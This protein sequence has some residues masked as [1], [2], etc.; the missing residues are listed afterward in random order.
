MSPGI[1][2]PPGVLSL[3]RC[4]DRGIIS[5]WG[6]GTWSPDYAERHYGELA[7]H[8]DETRTAGL[9]VRIL[10]N[11]QKSAALPDTVA[12]MCTM[13][14]AIFV[15]GD[16]LALVVESSTVKAQLRQMLDRIGINLFISETAA[17]MWLAPDNGWKRSDPAGDRTYQANASDPLSR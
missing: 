1:E 10:F 4:D 15:P 11:L 3:R 13:A 5:I 2:R 12:R 7:R 17:V 14:D 6:W 16:R 8:V 9:P